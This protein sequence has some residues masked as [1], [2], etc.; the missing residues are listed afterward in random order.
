MGKLANFS[1]KEAVKA[2]Q[3]LG[4]KFAVRLEATS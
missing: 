4:W 1:R 3:K 2:F